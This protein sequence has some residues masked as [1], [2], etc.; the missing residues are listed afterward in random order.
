MKEHDPPTAAFFVIIRVGSLKKVDNGI[1]NI[2]PR[3]INKLKLVLKG[4]Y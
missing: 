4:I 2:Y 3:K 1:F